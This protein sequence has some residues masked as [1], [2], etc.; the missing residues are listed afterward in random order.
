MITFL[1][2]PPFGFQL[3]YAHAVKCVIVL[4]VRAR[5]RALE[6]ACGRV[7]VLIMMTAG[8]SASDDS[9]GNVTSPKLNLLSAPKTRERSE[10]VHFEP[11]G[12]NLN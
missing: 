6:R 9:G 8:A 1:L 4:G 2:A 12:R 7:R 11:N 3:F 5:A 10:R